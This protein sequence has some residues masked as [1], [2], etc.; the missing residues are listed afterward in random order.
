M[1]AMRG[2]TE[3]SRGTTHQCL[4]VLGQHGLG[5]LAHLEGAAGPPGRTDRENPPSAIGCSATLCTQTCDLVGGVAKRARRWELRR[6]RAV[7]TNEKLARSMQ[8]PI[9]S[10]PRRPAKVPLPEPAM[11]KSVAAV[12][13]RY[14]SYAVGSWKVKGWV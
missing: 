1:E 5:Y 6:G 9:S 12:A 8:I 13:R 2:R 7:E 14:L 10:S 4:L 3:N 11:Q